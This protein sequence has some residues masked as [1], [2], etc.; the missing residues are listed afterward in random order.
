[1]TD[2]TTAVVESLRH[3]RTP[4]RP[5]RSPLFSALAAEVDGSSIDAFFDNAGRRSLVLRDVARALP[6][7]VLVADSGS[8]WDLELAG[9]RTD[10]SSWP[11]TVAG[12]ALGPAPDL[13]ETAAR[14]SATL[15]VIR[16]LQ[17]LVVP[18]TV[19]GVTVTGPV[20]FAALTGGE[21]SE[22]AK[23]LNSVVRLAMEAGAS[24]VLMTEGTAAPADA[25]AWERDLGPVWGTARFYQGIGA[26][27]LLDPGPAWSDVLGSGRAGRIPVVVDDAA[28]AVL[29]A[30][31]TAGAW[32]VARRPRDRDAG[33]PASASGAAIL[34][35]AGD[36]AGQVRVDA[37]TDVVR[38]LMEV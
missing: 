6:L 37:L 27:L 24:V 38:N 22:W 7:D 1:V 9:F 5:L 32:G 28:T 17:E 29:S 15:E 3:G 35:T 14:H 33:G 31:R 36:L 34:S 21:A 2:D 30:A 11:P 12:G 18:P 20:R 4:P 8:L 25:A 13:L 16:R 23:T 26:L 10:R 19:L